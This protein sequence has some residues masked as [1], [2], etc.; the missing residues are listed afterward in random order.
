MNAKVE[1]SLA[2]LDNLRNA[3]AAA[4]NKAREL[5]EAL[6]AARVLNAGAGGDGALLVQALTCALE[7]VRFAIGNLDPLTVRGWPCA[8]LL[9]LAEL[10]PKV[11]GVPPH[12]V[13]LWCDWRIFARRAAEWED[14]RAK[15]IEKDKL[16]EET[17]AKH[18]AA[19]HLGGMTD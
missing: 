10:L 17:L 15:G 5:A 1:I 7:V 18:P 3:R 11:P 13:E 12:V 14:A 16:H 9:A 4:E 2:D 8:H 19:D 6:D